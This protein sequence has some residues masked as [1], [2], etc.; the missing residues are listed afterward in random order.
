[1]EADDVAS[2]PRGDGSSS[3]G[4]LRPVKPE[5]ILLE[6][7]SAASS[8]GTWVHA[9]SIPTWEIVEGGDT[10][11]GAGYASFL[12]SIRTARGQYLRF[13]RRYTD[14]AV[15]HDSL[16][17]DYDNVPDIPPR[18]IV[19]RF[20]PAFLDERRRQLEWFLMEVLLDPI[21]TKS[22]SVRAFCHGQS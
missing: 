8:E 6:D 17:K 16:K 21:L 3:E 18:A 14:F 20:N 9:V 2:R 10:G 13:L 1:M 4:G 19:A 15:L 11:N 22:G 12:V 5:P 7:R